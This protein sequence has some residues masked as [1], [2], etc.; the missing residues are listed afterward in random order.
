MFSRVFNPNLILE[1]VSN[2]LFPCCI[3]NPLRLNIFL[4][5]LKCT[6]SRKRQCSRLTQLFCSSE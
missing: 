4:L 5:E 1:S 6:V 3:K 2:L